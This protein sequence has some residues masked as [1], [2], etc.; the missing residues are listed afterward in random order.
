MI[1]GL[2]VAGVDMIAPD[3]ARSVREQRGAIVEVNHNPGLRMHTHPTVGASRDVGGAIVDMLFPPGSP[4]RVPIVAVTGTNG[5]TTTTRMIAHIM[6]TAGKTVGMATTNGI[7]IAGTQIA[8]GDM[9]GASAARKVLQ[10]PAIDYAVLET[11]R[12]S[13]LRDGLGFD[14]CDV[15]VVTNVAAD[16]LGH[17]GIHTVT[18]MA[19]VKAVVPRAVAPGGASV[20]NADDPYAVG[21]AA[22]AAGEILFFSL[23]EQNPIMGQH[24]GQGG[25]AVVL[26]QT[27]A[28]EMLTLLADQVETEILLAEAIPATMGGRIRVNIANAQ[29]AIAA[30]LA[31]DVPL[32]TIRTALSGFA[33]SVAQT[34]GRFNLLEI[35][36]RTVVLDYFHNVHGL[37]AMADFVKRMGAPYTVAVIQM[38][39]DR[40][41][42]HIAAFGRLAAEIFDELVIRDALP[43]YRRR[44]NPGEIPARLRAAALA[45]GLAPDKVTLMPDHD[46]LE[47]AQVGI[48]K[49]GKDGLVV[50]FADD[51]AAVWSYLMQRQEAETAI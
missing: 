43:N 26:R 13:I 28:G 1:I 6:T 22:V 12:G 27:A 31:Q 47:A 49:G 35:E 16:H 50:L 44:R 5:K 10:N 9:A 34:P 30:A 11:A 39:G 15:A 42:D 40:T 38:A 25:R 7:S 46:E 21:M 41:D 48:A 23:D 18:D 19:K 8:A 33:N 14:H 32:E 36:G 20:L 2:D 24:V 37:E 45:G 3:I 29:A 51:A 17:K 4:S